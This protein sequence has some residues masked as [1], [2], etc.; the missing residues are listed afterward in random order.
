MDDITLMKYL[1]SK[2]INKNL[3][4][5][6]LLHKFKEFMY[7]QRN[8]RDYDSYDNYELNSFWNKKTRDFSDDFIE[9]YIY[10]YPSKAMRR[11]KMERLENT[12]FDEMSAKH[13]VSSM[14]HFE[15]GKKIIGEKFPMMKAKEVRERYRSVIPYDITIADVYVAINAQCHDYGELF[16]SWFGNNIENKII[17]SAILFWFKDEDYTKGSKLMNYFE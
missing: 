4:E 17:D 1:K 10:D 5:H 7:E 14:F 12:H 9:M 8:S 2:G 3:S 6:E 15:N 16:K 11:N 13:L